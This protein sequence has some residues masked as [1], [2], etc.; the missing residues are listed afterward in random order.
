MTHDK[1][2]V[3]AIIP[4]RGGSKTIPKKNILNIGGYP[5][6]A[7]SIAAAKLSKTIDRVI[8]STDSVE[9]AE[10]SK[11]YGA[12]VPFLRPAEISQDMSTDAEFMLH[13]IKWFK[14]NEGKVADYFV[15]LRPTSPLR[16]PQKIDE[17]VESIFKHPEVNALRSGHK[18]DTTPQ[19]LF[20]LVDGYFVGLFPADTRPEYHNLPRQTFPP[21]YKPDGYVDVLKTEFVEKT[22]MVHGDKILAFLTPDTGDI[23]YLSDLK[24]VQ[25]V[26]EERPWA[27]HEYLKKNFKGTPLSEILAS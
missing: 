24:Y 1:K 13:A 15:H 5:L 25:K 21:T 3:Y 26:V 11:K 6:I 20:G 9:I 19:K 17:A 4:A 10:I 16:D 12:E 18:V 22:G 7:Y 8:I 27:V 23:D 2:A 14:E